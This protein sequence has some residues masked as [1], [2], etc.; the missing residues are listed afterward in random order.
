MIMIIGA[1]ASALAPDFL[2]LVG[3]RLVWALASVAT[4]RCQLCS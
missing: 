2:F 4:T 3:A 1:V